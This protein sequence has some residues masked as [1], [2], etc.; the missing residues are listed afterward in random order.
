MSFITCIESDDLF[1]QYAGYISVAAY[2]WND[3]MY[4]ADDKN[5]DNF[6][7]IILK[8]DFEVYKKMLMSL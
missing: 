3:Y 4:V 8:N 7:E 1:L 2:I 5:M 6:D